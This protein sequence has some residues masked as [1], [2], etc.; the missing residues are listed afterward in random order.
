MPRVELCP[1]PLLTVTFRPPRVAFAAMVR[2]AT[3]WVDALK[4]QEFTAMPA[5][6]SHVSPA[7]KLLPVRIT[8][9][10]CPGVPEVGFN[11]VN[12]GVG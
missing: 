10:V 9:S 4:V 3:S 7:A 5:P 2:L 8:F 11:D 12:D 1:P 6:K